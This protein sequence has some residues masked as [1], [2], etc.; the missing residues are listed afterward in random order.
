MGAGEESIDHGTLR[1]LIDSG[2]QVD[3]EVVGGSG[4]WGLVIHVGSSKQRLAAARGEPRVFR[5]FETLA[6]YLKGFGITDFRVI[7][8]TFEPN[9]SRDDDRRSVTASRR[10]LAAHRAAAYDKWFRE[11]VQTAIDDPRP[12]VAD[13][14]ARRDFAAK[15]EALRKRA[16]ARH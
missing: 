14:D 11:Q 3:A 9:A 13:E 10:M 6:G 12:S 5:K 8:A 4:G 1:H 15:R 7:T 16:K 2:V